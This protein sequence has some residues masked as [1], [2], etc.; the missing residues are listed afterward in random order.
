MPTQ[1]SLEEIEAAELILAVDD[2][3]AAGDPFKLTAPMRALVVARLADLRTKDSA[4]F[5]TA[6]GRAG[7]SLAV[8]TALDTLKGHIRDGY[9]FVKGLGSDQITAADRLA[10]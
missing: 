8:R 7:A 4:T 6:G 3:R 2:G 10:V 9:N 5:V 1:Q